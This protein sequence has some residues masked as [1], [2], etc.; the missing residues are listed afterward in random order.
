M[1]PLLART[2]FAI[3]CFTLAQSFG[4]SLAYAQSSGNSYNQEWAIGLNWNTNGKM[5]GGV[6][7]RYTRRVADNQFRYYGL[8]WVNVKHEKEQKVRQN[9]SSSSFIPNKINYLLAVRPQYGRDF[10]LFRKAPE[11]GVHLNL[12]VSGGPSIGWLKPY[13]VMVDRGP[14]ETISQQYDPEKHNQRE[15]RGAA[16]PFD[17][18]NNSEFKLG[19][20]LKAG[21]Y[22]EVH[23]AT[24]HVLG[25]E[26]G[27]LIE[28]FAQDMPIMADMNNSAT[29]TSFYVTVFLLGRKSP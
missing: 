26:T 13:H 24:N 3:L 22:F 2:S 5:L 28:T 7:F 10:A 20:H 1:L 4:G 16:S 12:N 18:L 23:H 9:F 15:I 19:G 14:E 8:E 29:F 21:L 6:A 17:G 11:E 25:I 27:G